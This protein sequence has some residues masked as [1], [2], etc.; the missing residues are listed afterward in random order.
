MRTFVC[1][2]VVFVG[3]LSV[4]QRLPAA[5][6]LP[7]SSVVTVLLD[8]EQPYSRPSFEALGHQLQR[9]LNDAGVKIELRDRK[10]A[11][12]HEE[13]AGL[14]VFQMKGQCTMDPLPVD[15]LSDERGPLAMAYSADGTILPF[16][17]V[18]CDHV[19]QSIQRV[20]GRS[21]PKL[22][23]SVFGSA[24]G[25]VIA[26]EVY[27]MLAHSPAHTS[28]GVTK[29]SLSARELLDGRLSLPRAAKLAMRPQVTSSN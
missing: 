15:A 16:G 26:H 19:R 6:D 18:H 9:I 7:S 3:L 21:N 28:E 22:Y 10:Q 14:L 13:F 2:L 4:A 17:E 5:L 24:L 29:H 11:G 23:Q 27:H 1:S 25:L 20:V 8:Y 12:E